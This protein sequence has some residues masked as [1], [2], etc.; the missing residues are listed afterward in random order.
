MPHAITDDGIRIRYDT[1]G[2]RHGEPVLM[3]Q[4]LGADSRGWFAQRSAVGL[5]YRG[6]TF[7]NRGVGRSTKPV[8]PY[9]LEQM[10]ADAVAVLDAA[11]VESAHVMGASMGGVIAQIMAVRHPERVR[12]LVLA[13]TACRHLRWRRELLEDWASTAQAQGMRVF[14]N[15]S[16]RWLVGPRSLRRF[17]PAFGALTPLAMSAPTHSFVAQ[18]NAI[19]DMDDAL[20]GLLHTVAVPTLVLVGSQ[21]ILTPQA[22]AEEI[23]ELIPGAE[24]AVVQGGAHGFMVENFP[25]FNRIVLEFL[26]RVTAEGAYSRQ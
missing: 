1:F 26:A 23:A 20:R 9:D 6:I 10:A 22:D 7:D 24:L 16:M 11:G 13:C 15:R 17:W 8:G 19:L 14:A 2:R 18:V 4:G 5:R 3:I 12:S 25:A 21:D